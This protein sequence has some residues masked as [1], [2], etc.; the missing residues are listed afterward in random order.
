MIRFFERA[1][2]R[3]GLAIRRTQ[4]FNPKPRLVFPAPLSLGTASKNEHLEIELDE[5]ISPESV[6]QRLEPLMLPG[7]AITRAVPLPCHRK[8]RHVKRCRYLLQGW[9]QAPEDQKRLEGRLQQLQTSESIPVKRVTKRGSNKQVD[10][11]PSIEG[12]EHKDDGIWLTLRECPGA[13][14]RP[15]EVSS[16]LCEGSALEANS[17]SITRIQTEVDF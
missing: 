4:G 7:M 8:G 11:A 9:S 14:A 2:A 10:I 16:L 3:T 5:V 15:R 6:A 17:I 1:F 12:L 13:T